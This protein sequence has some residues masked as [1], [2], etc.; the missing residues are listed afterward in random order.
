MAVLTII[1]AILV[2]VQLVVVVLIQKKQDALVQ[3]HAHVLLVKAHPL[4][5]VIVSGVHSSELTGNV[6][7]Q[8]AP[9]ILVVDVEQVRQITVLL[10][11]FLQ[12]LILV[13]VI[14]LVVLT[15]IPSD[16]VYVQVVLAQ[17]IQ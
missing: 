1:Q 15:L 5:T 17:H 12:Q 11:F 8:V 7:A 6:N 2:S 14:L 9:N 3:H 13:H 16:I 10:E 4:I